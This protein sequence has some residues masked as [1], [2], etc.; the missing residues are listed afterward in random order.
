MKR[1]DY[2]S[3]FSAFLLLLIPLLTSG[4]RTIS[5]RVTDS[6][7]GGP[8]P[9]A[10][11]FIAETTVG[12][13][14]DTEGKF[15]LIL[16]GP[17]SFRLV[18]SH[19]GYQ[20]F[21]SDIEADWVSKEIIISLK[22]LELDEVTVSQKIIFRKEDIDLF[23]RTVL[24]TKPSK[25]KIYVM[26]PE[27]VYYYYNAETNQ[28]KVTCHEPLQIFN[29]E[30]GYQITYLL[31][32]FSHDYNTETTS[33]DAHHL[34]N[35]IEPK[36]IKQKNT[37]EIN[38]ENI[39]KV[40]ITNFLRALYTDSLSE[41]GFLLVDNNGFNKTTVFLRTN[42]IEQRSS[43][44]K[45]EE[46]LIHIDNYLT[47]DS[48]N[49]FKTFNIPFGSSLMLFSFGRPVYEKD[50]KNLNL[51]QNKKLPWWS[52]GLYRNEIRTPNGPV[53][54]F[55]DGTV[56]N[57]LSFSPRFSLKSLAGLNMMLPIEY[58]LDLIENDFDIFAGNKSDDS[59]QY[60]SGFNQQADSI[61]DKIFKRFETQLN[62]FPQEKVYVQTDKP[63]YLA[64]EK[65]WFRAHV[66]DAASRTPN[67]TAGCVYVELFNA[68]DSAV[69][70]VKTGINNDTYSGYLLIPKDVPEGDYTIR[71]YT[72]TMRNLD[73]DYFF[74][75]KHSNCQSLNPN[76]RR[77]AYLRLVTT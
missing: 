4:Q 54:F 18:V 29:L 40:S 53:Y 13:N 35:E 47:I 26:N 45:I 48:V 74:F 57:S 21:Y 64:G 38:R 2:C 22:T 28:L 56:K 33:W 76:A 49:N 30:T 41:K 55:S 69:C 31:D 7:D 61:Q 63:Y 12:T 70:R 71:A 14:T 3:F 17:G 37:W 6:T 27:A 24:G 5:G 36:N 66:V 23:W 52:I 51:A 34:F 75:E 8:I 44:K 9:Y 39:Y 10:S 67:L 77:H 11:V 65:I 72:N 73:E 59:P 62:L 15:R 25:N 32:R 20:T 43:N 68:M 46:V 19:V 58:K 1:T 16:P 42:P 60:V 50:L